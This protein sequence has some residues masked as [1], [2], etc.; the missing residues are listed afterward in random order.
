MA[1]KEFCALCHG[2]EGTR[3]RPGKTAATAAFLRSLAGDEI[4]TAVAFLTGRPFPASDPR[5]LEVSWA[6]L[7]EVLDAVG[8]AP[9]A[10]SLTLLLFV[11]LLPML[12]ELSQDFAGVFETHG[13]RTAL[14]VKYDGA[15]IQLH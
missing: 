11:P 12:A 1:F 3:S 6:I 14:E 13:G 2:L 10:S 15:R 9:V 5:V 8:P 4:P 7:S